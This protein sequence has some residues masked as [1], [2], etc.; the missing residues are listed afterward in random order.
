MSDVP[1]DDVPTKRKRD[2]IF[3]CLLE[4]FAP[5]LLGKSLGPRLGKRYGAIA[6]DLK[7]LEATPYDIRLR[8]AM[9]LGRFDNPS[10]QALVNHWDALGK[11]ASRANAS[12]TKVRSGVDYDKAVR[13]RRKRRRTNG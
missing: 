3:D 13:E 2:P 5:K 7:K 10:V 12:V 8:W 11:P 4:I 9:C 1:Q 6:A